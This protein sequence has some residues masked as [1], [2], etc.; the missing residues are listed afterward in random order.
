[1]CH[2]FNSRCALR[3]F[4][5]TSWRA[6]G[7]CKVCGCYFVWFFLILHLLL[8]RFLS[9]NLCCITKCMMKHQ[10]KDHIENWTSCYLVIVITSAY[11]LIPFTQYIGP[12]NCGCGV[13]NINLKCNPISFKHVSL[14]YLFFDPHLTPHQ[15]NIGV[16]LKKSN[17]IAPAH[18]TGFESRSIG[19]VLCVQRDVV[20][21]TQGS[22]E[23]SRMLM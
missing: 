19:N 22:E 4:Q 11:L 18:L 17:W 5:R 8:F 6:T 20:L 23:Q 16:W 3:L 7:C 14:R 15:S 21:D 12:P 13:H 1:M 9:T 2:V 10:Q